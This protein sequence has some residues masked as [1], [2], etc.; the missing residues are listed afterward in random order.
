[1]LDLVD[2]PI[3]GRL[4]SFLNASPI[5]DGGQFDMAINLVEKYGVVPQAIFPESYSSSASAP[6]NQLISIKL[7][8]F[9]LELRELESS[10]RSPGL[11]DEEIV[12][13]ARKRKEEM[14][15]QIYNTLCI[16]LGSPPKADVPF[17]YEYYDKDG[18][19]Q[20]ATVTPLEFYSKYTGPFLAKDMFSLINDPR[21]SYDKLYTVDRLGNVYGGLPVKYVNAPISALEHA[22]ITCI[23]ADQPVFFGCDVGASL[24]R[25]QGVMDIN[26]YE[27]EKAYGYKLNMDKAQRILTCSSAMTHAMVI[28]AVH[29][30]ASGNPVRYRIENSWSDA[31]GDKGFYL[32]TAE[33]FKQYVYQVVI[34]KKLADDKYVKIVD[35][36]E[37]IVLPCWDPMG[38]LA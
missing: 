32:M 9:G 37:A 1:M 30:D 31:T 33:W 17:D 23:K 25:E 21:N 2:E 18:K 16:T 5:N 4:I 35:G 20:R 15:K 26:A 36:D 34:P 19:F 11:T 27:Y 7:R 29:L 38:A 3:D 13:A 24:L 28:T 14:M 10:L 22:V 8:E 6:L 12:G